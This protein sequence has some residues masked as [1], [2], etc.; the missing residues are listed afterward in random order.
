LLDFKDV[1]FS[2]ESVMKDPIKKKSSTTTRQVDASQTHNSTKKKASTAIK[3][4][5]YII[6]YKSEQN[7]NKSESNGN[8]SE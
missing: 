2:V 7:S 1:A 6:S 3:P 8:N 4:I 5:Q